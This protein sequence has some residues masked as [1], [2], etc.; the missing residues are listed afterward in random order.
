MYNFCA[1]EIFPHFESATVYGVTKENSMFFFL[2]ILN[3]RFLS[4]ETDGKAYYIFI[5]WI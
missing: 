2:I 3:W 4:Q 1:G 5:S